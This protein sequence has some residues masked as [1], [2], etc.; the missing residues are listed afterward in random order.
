VNDRLI[1]KIQRHVARS[2]PEMKDAKPSVKRKGGTGDG[3]ERFQLTFKAQ[4]EVP[5]GRKM[6]RVVRVVAD[7]HGKVLRMS[8]S[9]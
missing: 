1:S 4:A 7:E 8:S 3:E 9:K 5:G 6:S 2:Y